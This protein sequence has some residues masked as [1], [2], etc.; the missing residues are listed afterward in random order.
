MRFSADRR[1]STMG[2]IISARAYANNEVAYVAWNIDGKIKD[3][4]GF[5]VTRVYLDESGH[6][7]RRPDGREDRVKCAAWV[8]FKGQR[9][10]HWIPQD[11]GV[12]PVQKHS[13]LTT[14]H[15]LSMAPYRAHRRCRITSRRRKIKWAK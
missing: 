3:C 6:V 2:S 1:G 12:W 9:N 10:P 15:C 13:A 5:E 7:A 14:N 11:T 4:L 8:A